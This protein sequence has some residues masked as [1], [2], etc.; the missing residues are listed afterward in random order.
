MD[1]KD[2]Q[3]IKVITGPVQLAYDFDEERRMLC[4]WVGDYVDEAPDTAQRTEVLPG[5][6]GWSMEA[7]N[8]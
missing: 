1:M 8:G 3:I 5:F 2:I 6:V 7:S 4:I